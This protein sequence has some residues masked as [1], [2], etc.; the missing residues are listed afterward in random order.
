[1]G[2][3]QHARSNSA[4]G[5]TT[6]HCRG[7]RHVGGA[8]QAMGLE[9]SNPL[10]LA[11]GFD[12]T[13]RLV[14]TLARLG[15][16][17]IE[18]GTI[19]PGTANVALPSKVPAGLRLG[20]NIG[21]PRQGL[22]ELVVSDYVAALARVWSRADFVSAN[23]TSPFL[24]RDGDTPGID[25][26]I[27]H[28]SVAWQELCRATDRPRPLLVKVACGPPGTAVPGAIAS[29][30][31]H[32]L[33]GIVLVSTS[34]QQIAAVRRELGR[35]VVIS[36]GGV[37]SAVDVEARLAA[38]ASLVQIYRAFVRDGPGA[39]QRILSELDVT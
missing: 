13:G 5:D 24:A 11:A 2:E 17:H 3:R 30:R 21:S 1:M 15:F 39:P 23:L 31:R 33:S 32:G 10:G 38:G 18:V 29:V 16:G 7:A 28:L 8:V 14:P 25:R 12:R 37:E 6:Q 22:D 9:F 35:A 4:C 20:V 27:E 26:L 36:V 34:P 19:T